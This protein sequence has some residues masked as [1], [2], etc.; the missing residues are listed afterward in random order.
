MFRM[1]AFMLTLLGST[2]AWGQTAYDPK[3]AFT[4]VSG[5]TQYLYLANADG[6]RAVRAATVGRDAYGFPGN[7]HGVDFA[8]GGGRIA[9]TDSS[10]L[11]VLTYTASN[12]GIRVDRRDL[13]VAG[14]YV[15]SPDFSPDGSRILYRDPDMGAMRVVGVSGGSP[16]TL[17]TAACGWARWLR[18]ANFGNAFACY[19]STGLQEPDG[20]FIYEVWA[21][22]LDPNDTVASTVLVLTTAGQSF[23]QISEFDTART[24]DALLMLVNYATGP[25]MVEVDIVSG[26]VSPIPQGMGTRIHYSSDDSRILFISPHL[27]AG[28]Y[29]S[30][31]D[32]A[33][34]FITRL[35]KKGSYGTTDA[36]P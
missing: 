12:S 4:Q 20:S 27:A 19:K 10:G 5:N 33:T 35:T 29:V 6:T 3:I 16:V 9:Y 21:V 24:R 8:P 26:A 15:N 11:T 32:P 14:R 13:L 31:L 22:Y 25:R 7:I 34:G 2:L 18:P 23:K 30:S 36:R 1:L 17:Y 28:D